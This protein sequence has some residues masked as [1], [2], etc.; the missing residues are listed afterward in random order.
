MTEPAPV[1]FA[2]TCGLLDPAR[3]PLRPKSG[4]LPPAI[5]VTAA[6]ERTPRAL[7]VVIPER[8]AEE[9]ENHF[10]QTKIEVA[11][12]IADTQK[13][14]DALRHACEALGIPSPAEVRLAESLLVDGLTSIA[15]RLYTIAIVLDADEAA[16]SRAGTRA[17]LNEAPARPGKSTS[18]CVIVEHCLGLAKA[19]TFV[20]FRLPQV[21]VSS[22]TKDYCQNG[23]L[24][25]DLQSG[26]EAA[27]LHYAANLAEART[28]LRLTS[29]EVRPQ[30]SEETLRVA[31]AQHSATEQMWS[32][33][34][35]S[36]V[37]SGTRYGDDVYE[38]AQQVKD[39]DQRLQEGLAS[40]TCNET[41]A[42]AL[43]A[44]IGKLSFSL[45]ERSHGQSTAV[46]R[47]Q[48]WIS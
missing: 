2:D 31:A 6:A 29:E 27:G 40:S 5:V 8:V 46:L 39:L 33:I 7:W 14:L 17:S 20:G 41:Q 38:L 21:F 32:V 25:P 36:R 1:L 3:A 34:Q 24:H 16:R 10:D 26:F 15:Q 45:M 22:N 42:K 48:G 35:A 23:R 30:V 37:S 19:L 11:R 47:T 4:G 28:P 43:L 18:D 12:H 44:E 13:A 9:W